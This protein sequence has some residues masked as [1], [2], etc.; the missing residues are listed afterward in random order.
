MFFSF[1]A[2]LI[3]IM[4]KSMIKKRYDNIDL[5]DVNMRIV[6]SSSFFISYSTEFRIP[7]RL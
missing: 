3:Y 6:V 2:T 5:E 4:Y 1:K 7:I